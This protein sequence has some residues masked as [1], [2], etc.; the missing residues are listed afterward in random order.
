M[1]KPNFNPTNF[2][3]ILNVFELGDDYKSGKKKYWNVHKWYERQRMKIIDYYKQYNLNVEQENYEC[4]LY[5]F[6]AIHLVNDIKKT[7]SDKKA[8]RKFSL[9]LS[10][11]FRDMQPILETKTGRH[12]TKTITSDDMSFFLRFFKP[13]SEITQ[14]LAYQ[15]T[16]QQKEGVERLIADTTL[17]PEEKFQE[18]MLLFYT[19]KK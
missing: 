11:C 12:N 19:R 8:F 7:F 3:R 10:K 2:R 4:I 13:D 18:L 6:L 16:N 5:Y 14:K 1:K 9:I 17:T 15:L